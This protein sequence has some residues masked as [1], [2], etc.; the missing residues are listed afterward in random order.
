MAE[1][2]FYN[3]RTTSALRSHWKNVN[4]KEYEMLIH[5]EVEAHSLK[6]IKICKK[7]IVHKRK[8]NVKDPVDCNVCKHPRSQKID[9][10]LNEM[11]AKSKLCQRI[12]N[13]HRRCYFKYT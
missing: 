13:I 8:S 5:T 1:E 10:W 6:L 12:S 11:I 9:C 7:T 4:F 3:G 2:L